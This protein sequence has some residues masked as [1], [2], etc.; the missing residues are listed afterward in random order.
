MAN[1][2]KTSLDDDAIWRVTFAN[3][4]GNILDEATMVA[5][6]KVFRDATQTPTLK[7]ICLEGEGKHFSF[8]ASIPEHM[9]GKVVDMLAAFRELALAMLESHVIIVAAV[10]G[11][12]LGAGL[13]VVTLCHRVFAHDDAMFGQPE[14]ILGV[15]APVASIAFADRVG[16]ANAEDLC[17]T[18]R[19][20]DAGTAHGMGMVQT[21][22]ADPTVAAVDWLR[23]SVGAKSASSLRHAVRAARLG[24]ERRLRADL[25][26]LEAQYLNELMKTS[27]AIEG[28]T[29]FVEKRP[30]EWRH[31]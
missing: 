24:L 23:E 20:I 1:V 5:L 11:Q 18:G 15:F 8:G 29:A 13:E 2:T 12:C 27:D 9:P 22:H 26:L 10:R 16:Q 25:P 31:A 30:A 14:I 17:L 19:S 7:A 4:K 28:L 21:I 6:T 3:G